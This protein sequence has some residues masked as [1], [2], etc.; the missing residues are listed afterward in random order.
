MIFLAPHTEGMQLMMHNE[1]KYNNN[2]KYLSK[3]PI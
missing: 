1:M 3:S 2:F